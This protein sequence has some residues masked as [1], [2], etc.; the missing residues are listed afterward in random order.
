MWA[1]AAS[2][3]NPW[4][5]ARL[6]SPLSCSFAFLLGF[7]IRSTC[8]DAAQARPAFI[9]ALAHL[10]A[11][12]LLSQALLN[13]DP[14][15]APNRAPLVSDPP[16]PAVFMDSGG[17]SN[18][19]PSAGG[20]HDHPSGPAARRGV[21]PL[22]LHGGVLPPQSSSA[23]DMC[24]PL[25]SLSLPTPRVT[26]FPGQERTPLAPAMGQPPTLGG[27]LQ[28]PFAP[29]GGGL[30]SPIAPGGGGVWGP[31]W[32]PGA[33]MESPVWAV[34]LPVENGWGFPSPGV[35]D[36]VTAAATRGGAG[37]PVAAAAPA[38]GS[39]DSSLSLRLRSMDTIAG[40]LGGGGGGWGSLV[41]SGAGTCSGAGRSQL[42]GL[43][44]PASGVGAACTARPQDDNGEPG[45]TM[46]APVGGL[47]A[48]PARHAVRPPMSSALQPQSG[49]LE[50]STLPSPPSLRVS[51][52]MQSQ[53]G[54][55]V[56][57]ELHPQSGLAV[58][59]LGEVLRW[60]PTAPARG[61][62]PHEEKP[63]VPTVGGMT[64][65]PDF[66]VS[67]GG[68]G[69]VGDCGG[70]RPPLPVVGSPSPAS[71][72][73]AG[74]VPFQPHA[75]FQ[76]NP[77]VTSSSDSAAERSASPPA[78]QESPGEVTPLWSPL[79]PTG[80][81]RGLPLG[82]PPP[83]WTPL[84]SD[85]AHAAASS[86][87]GVD[88]AIAAVGIS[89]GHAVAG[90]GPAGSS[91][92]GG[93]GLL[94]ADEGASHPGG[95]GGAPPLGG[96]APP[97]GGSS[98]TSPPAAPA[99][100]DAP[101]L[102]GG[103]GTSP[104]AVPVQEGGEAAMA[105]VAAVVETTAAAAAHEWLMANVARLNPAPPPPVAARLSNC[106]AAFVSRASRR[107]RV[108]A[109]TRELTAAAG[110]TAVKAVQAA[111]RRAG[112]AARDQWKAEHREEREAAR[113]K[114][115]MASDEVA[116][117]SVAGH[118]GGASG[119][120]EAAAVARLQAARHAVR[121]LANKASSAGQRAAQVAELEALERALWSA[122]GR[123][124]GGSAP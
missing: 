71:F 52:T 95:G 13:L 43:C 23:M 47:P 57:S 22:A 14:S 123:A 112:E 103:S 62:G 98:D 56:S 54:W 122:Y 35:L 10:P 113:A 85:L 30:P 83:S 117:A 41:A 12:P 17:E 88:G 70:G 38:A 53:A 29:G 80:P 49:L 121:T 108:W 34:P 55:P 59:F 68:H 72:S 94:A 115:R 110:D 106:K 5:G 77:V 114:V 36:V 74:G 6:G 93:S 104:G 100:G 67:S 44:F 61:A 32:S 69:L 81:I 109:L 25:L 8:Q 87:T 31:T 84:S 63:P 91:G 45:A 89:T 92:R 42:D 111:S 97:P 96:G 105:R 28:S 33:G 76:S 102:V 27:G 82:P 99:G 66:P 64:E 118:G 119:D 78:G 60:A 75:F 2:L 20:Q 15:G 1:G 24:S 65:L 11:V 48:P 7:G 120:E 16:R 51:S 73:M 58:G 107:A 4:L 19:E 18:R 124:E 37:E 46:A 40:G 26:A 39:S 21:P 9:L 86:L 101:P 3:F 90:G 116:Y 50:S 79:A